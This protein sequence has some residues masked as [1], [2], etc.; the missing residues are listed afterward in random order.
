MVKL[1]MSKEKEEPKLHFV[2]AMQRLTESFT[3][4]R[5]KEMSD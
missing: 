2:P 4:V 1:I 3:K 5:I